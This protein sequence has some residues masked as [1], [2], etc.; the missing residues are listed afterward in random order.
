MKQNPK[1]STLSTPL[2]VFIYCNLT[3]HLSSTIAGTK[4]N[5]KSLALSLIDIF[6]QNNISHNS[7]IVKRVERVA[8]TIPKIR[9]SFFNIFKSFSHFVQFG[10]SR[11]I[12]LH[13]NN[14][15]I[16]LFQCSK[17]G[18]GRFVQ[19]II[20]SAQPIEGL[21]YG[22]FVF[23]KLF[24]PISLR[25]MTDFCA[26]DFSRGEIDI[27]TY[28]FCKRVCQ[29]VFANRDDVFLAVR[30]V[31]VFVGAVQLKSHARNS[32]RTTLKHGCHCSGINGVYRSIASVI[33]SRNDQVALS[34]FQNSVKSHLDTIDRSAVE[35]I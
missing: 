32:F 23:D 3:Y 33:Y 34:C 31:G 1:N 20:Y 11:K 25:L 2:V 35:G 17:V 14:A 12:H 22:V 29:Y 7:P 26:F 15:R 9:L 6:K 30:K 24:I 5:K 8:T 28:P 4:E 19:A 13:G 27:E 10:V 16:S 18:F 21:I